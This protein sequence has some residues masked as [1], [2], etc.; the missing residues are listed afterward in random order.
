MMDREEAINKYEDHKARGLVDTDIIPL[1][2]KI[3]KLKCCYTTS[4][5]SGRIALL[6]L[7]EIGDKRNAVF[8]G[9]WHREI[10]PDEIDKVLNN[11]KRGYLFFLV[12]SSII[13]VVCEGIENAM[14]MIT[15][16]RDAG[17]KYTSIKSIKNDKILIEILSTENLHIPLGI[18]GKIKVDKKSIIFFVDVA[19]K[20]LERIKGK[21][22]T[23]KEKIS[24]LEPSFCI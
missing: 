21:L 2:E 8:I 7:P 10:V 19:N 12:Q 1:L 22:K 6:Q 20:M 16:A 9:K 24:F 17:F 18:N 23:L 5:C 15:I 14:K 13:H 11:Y 3:N 4:S